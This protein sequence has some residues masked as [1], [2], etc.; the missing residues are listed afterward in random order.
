MPFGTNFDCEN[1]SSLPCAS[2]QDLFN[3][4]AAE[5]KVEA[6]FQR[7]DD[8]VGNVPSQEVLSPAKAKSSVSQVLPQGGG[9]GLGQGPLW[10]HLEGAEE[11]R[12]EEVGEESTASRL[13]P[14]GEVPQC[15][16]K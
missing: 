16:S 8:S 2:V 12:P 6:L 7:L 3:A 15:F 13:F 10:V 4:P 9:H 14:R 1:F 11:E 5:Q